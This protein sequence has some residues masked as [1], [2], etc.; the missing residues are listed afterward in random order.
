MTYI[1]KVEITVLYSLLTPISD[2]LITHKN[3]GSAEQKWYR[4]FTKSVFPI[5]M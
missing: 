4:L 3:C 2:Q 5:P 1:A